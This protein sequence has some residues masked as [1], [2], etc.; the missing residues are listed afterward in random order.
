MKP[1]VWNRQP[2]REESAAN[3]YS[4]HTAA[5]SH[6][7]SVLTYRFESGPATIRTLN[8]NSNLYSV[9]DTGNTVGET[10][11]VS[12]DGTGWEGWNRRM[13]SFVSHIN[14]QDWT[15][16]YGLNV[17]VEGTRAPLSTTEIDSYM[18]RLPKDTSETRKNIIRYALQSV[19]KVPVLLG[20]KGQRPE[21][22]WQQFRFRH[23]PGP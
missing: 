8:E 9:D 12:A 11:S 1:V 17:V 22:Y 20:W 3:G 23:A 16:T 15:E 14:R 13:M 6:A 4:V 18:S 19:G 7:P 5:A 21:L 10:E 2:K